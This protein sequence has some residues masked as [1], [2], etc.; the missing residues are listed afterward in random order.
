MPEAFLDALGSMPPAAGNAL[1]ID[2]LAM[3][4]AGTETIDEVSAF[5]PEEH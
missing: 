2:R 5:I 3:L 1:G 4:L